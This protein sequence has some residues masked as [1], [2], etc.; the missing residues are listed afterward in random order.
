[1]VYLC[2]RIKDLLCDVLHDSCFVSMNQFVSRYYGTRKE[3]VIKRIINH[4]FNIYYFL[5]FRNT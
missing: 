4:R 2:L 1:M 5:H 3:N